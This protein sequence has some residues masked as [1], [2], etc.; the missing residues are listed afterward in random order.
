MDTTITPTT[1][2]V[3]K[4]VDKLNNAKN[5]PKGKP[6]PSLIDL[7]LRV[8]AETEIY[9]SPQAFDPSALDVALSGHPHLAKRAKELAAPLAM[10]GALTPSAIGR[11][12][13]AALSVLRQVRGA[14]HEAFFRSGTDSEHVCVGMISK[15]FQV[16]KMFE[17]PNVQPAVVSLEL[18]P[19][20]TGAN[21]AT[22]E[23]TKMMTFQE[24]EAALETWRYELSCQLWDD[25]YE[26]QNLLG[27]DPGAES[28]LSDIG[29][30]RDL[31]HSV[32]LAAIVAPWPPVEIHR[33][34]R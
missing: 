7:S 27:I 13:K 4:T 25:G 23:Q 18:D 15:F 28:M 1:A 31:L 30:R 3:S 8:W 24:I 6:V 33:E 20:S 2:P 10:I 5:A 34:G 26:A 17:I 29:R 9:D 32:D 14:P 19:T 16:K 12:P 11:N 22:S 21:E